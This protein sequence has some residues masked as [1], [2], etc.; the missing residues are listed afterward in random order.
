LKIALALAALVAA[1]AAAHASFVELHAA[2]RAGTSTGSG[3]GGAQ[4]DNDFF[5]GAK[6]AAFGAKVG[7]QLLFLDLSVSHDQFT[8][9]SEVRGT[10][11]QL[12]LGPRFVFPLNEGPA[13]VLPTLYADLG[14][15]VG[16]GIGTGQQIE[17]PL[18]DAEVSDKG[19]VFELHIGIEY[20]FAK[21]LGIGVTAPLAWGYLVKNDIP[22]TDTDGHYHSF[23]AM[24]L[25]TLSLH[26]GL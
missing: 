12:T 14:A 18:D 21:V 11:T 24:L 25:G 23:H 6:G 1:P 10:W 15:A 22:I 17:P 4:K 7:V 26:I 19:V 20:R 3:L 16:Y 13:G 9:F 2:L 5:A 8:N